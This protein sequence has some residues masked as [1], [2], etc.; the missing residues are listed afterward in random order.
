MRTERED[1]REREQRQSNMP[2][3]TYTNLR[4]RRRVNFQIWVGIAVTIIALAVT[5]WRVQ[6]WQFLTTLRSV[7]VGFILIGVAFFTFN[8]GVRAIRWRLLLRPV[9]KTT[10]LDTF[11]YLMVG[12]VA[13]NVLP[14]RIGELI[15]AY[16]LARQKGASSSALL[17]TIVVERVFDILLLIVFA[18]ALTVFMDVPPIVQASVSSVGALAVLV[19]GVLLIGSF[20]TTDRLI[21]LQ[22]VL[23]KHLPAP[24]VAKLFHLATT[25]ITG[26]QSLKS[27]RDVTAVVSLS[28][29]AWTFVVCD[30]FVY[31]KAFHLDLPWLAAM[32][33]VMAVNL[34]T[35]VPSSPGAF[36]VAHFMFVLALGMWGVDR[37][38]ALGFAVVR[39]G[40]TYLLTT[41]LG[42]L[43]LWTT[44]WSLGSI[45][46][47]GKSASVEEN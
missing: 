45:Y 20:T 17:A 22:E 39:H 23:E 16:L 32:F 10:L 29:L 28:V 15:R 13:N 6:W 2:A 12:Y 19:L 31:L 42:L 34:G 11:S 4:T 41:G 30:A 14:L 37:E 38:V 27:A 18:I 33:T 25:F 40:V 3:S 9:L 5:F 36:G 24:I 7:N 47:L 1:S 8:L 26:L 35:M 43:C 46:K 44:G 21:R